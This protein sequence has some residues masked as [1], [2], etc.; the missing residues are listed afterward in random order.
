MKSVE[1]GGENL[2]NGCLYNNEKLLLDIY[3]DLD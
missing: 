3:G 2:D 1:R